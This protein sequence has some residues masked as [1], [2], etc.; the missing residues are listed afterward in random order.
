VVSRYRPNSAI[1]G[2]NTASYDQRGRQLRRPLFYQSG[3]AMTDLNAEMV[4]KIEAHLASISTSLSWISTWVAL[5]FAAL[6]LNRL[7]FKVSTGN[8]IKP[9]PN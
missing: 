6:I 3:V 4:A 9:P 8:F 1:R 7:Q 2:G 5:G